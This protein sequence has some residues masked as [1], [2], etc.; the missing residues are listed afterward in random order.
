MRNTTVIVCE[1]LTHAATNT[2]STQSS[3][4]GKYITAAPSQITSVELTTDVSGTTL[5]AGTR[6]RILGA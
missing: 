1:S 2:A 6:I 3:G 5:S 4:G